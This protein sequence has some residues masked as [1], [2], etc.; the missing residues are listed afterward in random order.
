MPRRVAQTMTQDVCRAECFH[1]ALS[2]RE[3]LWSAVCQHRFGFLI[4]RD[5][6]GA[7]T[8]H[9]KDRLAERDSDPF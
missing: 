6:S 5:K 3:A 4:F 9:A 8:P 1:L 2:L 7:D